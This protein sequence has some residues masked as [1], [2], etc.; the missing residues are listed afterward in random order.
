MLQQAGFKVEAV[1]FERNQDPGRA[2]NCP[3]ASL[4]RI[5]HGKYAARIAS[6]LSAVRKARPAVRRNDLLYAFNSDMAL[7]ASLA[8]WGLNKPLA[9]ETGDILGMQVAGGLGGAVRAVDKC[10]AEHCRL[11]VLTSTG[12]PPYYRRWLGVKTPILVVENKLP[13]AFAAEVRQARPPQQAEAPPLGRPWR[14]GWFGILREPW[15]LRVLDAL[16]RAAPNRFR[17]VL[18]GVFDRPMRKAGFDAHSFANQVKN[19]NIEYRG[20]YKWPDDLPALYDGVDLVMDCYRAAI[21]VSWSQTNRYYEGCL[22]GKPL[23]VRAGCTDAAQVERQDIGLVLEGDDA[24]EAAHQISAQPDAAWMR[25]RTNLGRLPPPAYS[26]ID[27]VEALG[28]AMRS[29]L[30][31][32]QQPGSKQGTS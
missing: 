6:L 24:Q 14:I 11:L 1:A 9:Q 18:A 25:W 29:L 12:Y 15:N 16:T 13:A 4:G 21:P 10:I 28:E 8:G 20:P 5:A 32:S 26:L 31:Q 22:F 2:P 3:I 19:P 30:A 23:I 7:L 17:A 27:E